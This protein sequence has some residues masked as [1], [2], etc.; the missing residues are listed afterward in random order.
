[1]LVLNGGWDQNGVEPEVLPWAEAVRAQA[2]THTLVHDLRRRLAAG[3]L[4]VFTS[5]ATR[6]RVVPAG[7]RR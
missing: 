3:C 4:P 2:A 5:D 7:R 1:M 6:R